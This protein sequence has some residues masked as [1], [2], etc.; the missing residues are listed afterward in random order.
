LPRI[1]KRPY[2][3]LVRQRQA[4]D[5]RRRIVEATRRLLQSEGYAGMTIEAIA[6]R[7]EVSAQSVYAIFK[8]KTGVLTELLDQ[9]TFG[10]DYEDAVRQ[11]LSASDPET[12]LRL[13]APIARQIHD[14]QSATFDLLRGAGVV[15]PELAKLEQQRERLRYER[16]ERMIISLRDARRLRPGLDH[17]TARDIFWM[18][19]GRDVYRMLVRE[20]GWSSQKY[21][22]WLADT[23]VHSLLTPGRPSPVRSRAMKRDSSVGHS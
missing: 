2:K 23:L 1:K 10:A 8:S 9:S 19:T 17:G 18:L 12:R 5:T 13:T 3:S 6:Q 4:G 20:R 16:Q 7:A 22:D 21:Q 14:A 15:A 11:A